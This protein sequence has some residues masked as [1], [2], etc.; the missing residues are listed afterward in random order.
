[1][2]EA[3]FRL[4]AKEAGLVANPSSD[5][6][7]G[8]DFEVEPPS[9]AVLD[10]ANQSRPVFRIQVKATAGTKPAV[11]MSFSSLLSLVQ[12]AGPA[13]VVLLRFGSDT[14]PLEGYLLHIDEPLR[15]EILTTLRK[16]EIAKPG[17]APNR[18]RMNLEIG[19]GELINPLSGAEL[20]RRME[21]SVGG[22]YYDYLASKAKWLNGIEDD[23]KQLRCNLLLEDDSELRS[24]ANCHL[25]FETP[26]KGSLVGYI[27][28]MGIPN[29]PLVHP[30]A[31]SPITIKPLIDELPRA[32]LRFTP[33][34][35]GPTYVFEA[36]VYATPHLLPKQLAAM[37][38]HTAI[39][40]IVWRNEP[41]SLEFI[42]ADLSDNNLLASIS[43][44]RNYIRYM[45]SARRTNSTRIEM[46]PE[47]GKSPLDLTLK[48]IVAVPDAFDELLADVD[49]LF[50]KLVDLNLTA[51]MFCVPSMLA[52]RG[53]FD[54]LQCIGRP[55]DSPLSFEFQSDSEIIPDANVAVF[56]SQIQ[57]IGVTVVCYGAFYGTV[58]ALEG[59]LRG[60][61]FRS[62]YL[63]DIIVRDDDE[64]DNTRRTREAAYKDALRSQ[65]LRVQM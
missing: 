51:E 39:F 8:W 65:G 13:F 17:F 30:T 5:D 61:F 28:P 9:P 4:L 62:E 48:H 27:A 22:S 34:P 24:L 20:R 10:F 3:Y 19:A 32:K 41:S 29:P 37:R 63:G 7:A 52:N 23:S 2:G 56:S 38:W 40:D 59:S 21:Q 6:K 54:F 45:E 15:R 18:T 46:L 36:I 11:S 1:M 14:N 58:D 12:F 43:E 53:L 55:Y 33:D 16:R 31:F 64:L 47:D 57:L 26:F 50:Y 35:L 60:N 44:L 42:A 49:R 25:G